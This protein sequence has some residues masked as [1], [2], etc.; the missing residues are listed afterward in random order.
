MSKV[1]YCYSHP[2]KEYLVKNGEMMI[3]SGYHPRTHKKFW[4]FLRNDKL[5][6]L[7]EKWSANRLNMAR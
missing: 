1:Y 2:Q 6:G 3:A 4:I 5:D 7:L